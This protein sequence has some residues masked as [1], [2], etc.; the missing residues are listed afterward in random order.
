MTCVR[1]AELDDKNVLSEVNVADT[2]PYRKYRAP[3]SLYVGVSLFVD[4][5]HPTTERRVLG[6]ALST[7]SR[8]RVNSHYLRELTL[9]KF[10]IKYENLTQLENIGQGNSCMNLCVFYIPNCKC[11]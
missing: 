6:S 2:N 7:D 10:I 3:P 11:S 9:G 8:S 1:E 4:V 5:A